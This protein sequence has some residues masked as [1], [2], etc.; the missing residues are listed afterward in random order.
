MFTSWCQRKDVVSP[1]SSPNMIIP[2][3]ISPVCVCARVCEW[4]SHQIEFLILSCRALASAPCSPGSRPGRLP[5]P[6]SGCWGSSSAITAGLGTGLD[7]REGVDGSSRPEKVKRHAVEDVAMPTGQQR[8]LLL[9]L[10][11]SRP[12]STSFASSPDRH[13]SSAWAAGLR[14]SVRHSEMHSRV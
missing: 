11:L 5:A 2:S 12:P 6:R 10:L 9:L 8:A 1:P 3:S 7:R 13:Q 4:T 14:V